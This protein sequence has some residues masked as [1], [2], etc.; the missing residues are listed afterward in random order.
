MVGFRRGR[1]LKDLLVRAKLPKAQE[2]GE[3]GKCMG[4]RCQV[5]DFV[6]KTDQFSKKD[7]PQTYVI[8]GKNLNFNS[9]NV[10]YLVNCKTCNVQYIGSASTKFRMRFNNY[11]SCF[12]RYTT[13]VSVPQASFHA[14][15][16]QTDHNGMND[17][18]FTLI[19]HATNT[20][21][22]RWK[23]MYW[24]YKSNTF[25]PNGLNERDVTLDYG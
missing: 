8:Q 3:S 10:V 25:K 1:S 4:K 12:N 19:D 7:D 15:F 23:E 9:T 18:S 5:C 22:L 16:K 13:G 20:K 2:K 11:R 6:Q 17:W 21:A 14:H 24:Q